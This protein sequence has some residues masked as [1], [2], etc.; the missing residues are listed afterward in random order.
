MLDRALVGAQ[1]QQVL[2]ENWWDEGVGPPDIEC[3]NT[4][5][6]SPIITDDMHYMCRVCGS[7]VLRVQYGDNWT[8]TIWRHI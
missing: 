3:L 8:Q 5:L 6:V 4:H 1:I 7:A 2:A